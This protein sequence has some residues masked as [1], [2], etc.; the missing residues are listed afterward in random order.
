MGRFCHHRSKLQ[1]R[2]SHPAL[3]AYET[4]LST[5]SPASICVE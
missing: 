2:V 4:P 5:G 3:G 1:V